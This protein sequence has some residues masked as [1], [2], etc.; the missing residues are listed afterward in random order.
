MH[1][2]FSNVFNPKYLIEFTTFQN[3]R[4]IVYKEVFVRNPTGGENSAEKT[5]NTATNRV[6]I[7]KAD[8]DNKTRLPRRIIKS[9]AKDITVPP[10]YKIPEEITLKKRFPFVGVSEVALFP[11]S[12]KQ[13]N[14]FFFSDETRIAGTPECEKR[15]LQPFAD[16]SQ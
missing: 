10:L 8:S 13:T 7:K 16:F 5:N 11:A 9:P 15:M 4:D 2:Y 3:H 1:S 6:T 12:L 14:Q